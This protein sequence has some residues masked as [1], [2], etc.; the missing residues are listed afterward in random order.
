MAHCHGWVNERNLLMH[1]FKGRAWDQVQD[2][3]P[4]NVSKRLST[5]INP[6]CHIAEYLMITYCRNGTIAQ[7][8]PDDCI[9]LHI[10]Y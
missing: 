7:L 6:H 8:R 2:Y 9:G 3:A 10:D 1:A 5:Q 4:N